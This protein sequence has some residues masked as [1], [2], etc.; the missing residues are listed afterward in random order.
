MCHEIYERLRVQAARQVKQPKNPDREESAQDAH[1][2]PFEPMT[3]NK[4]EISEE[5]PA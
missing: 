5:E 1:T 2:R 3:P 4:V